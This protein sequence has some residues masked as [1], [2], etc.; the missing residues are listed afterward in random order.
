MLINKVIDGIEKKGS[1]SLATVIDGLH[2]GCR[3]CCVNNENMYELEGDMTYETWKDLIPLIKTAKG[4]KIIDYKHSKILIEHFMKNPILVI[5]GGGHISVPIS[6]IGKMLGFY[7]QVI[8]DREEFADKERFS[9]ADEV[10]CCPFDRLR[11][12]LRSERNTYYVIVTRGH[13][14]DLECA[15][16][17][18]RREFVYAGMIGSK[19]KVAK[20]KNALLE[21]GV[22][23]DKI[24]QLHS[25]IG[26]DIGAQT[27]EEIA[28]SIA[29]EI[30]QDKYKYGY[31]F[32][33]LQLVKE[34]KRE[35]LDGVLVTIIGKTGSSPRGCGSKMFVGRD[36][37]VI[38]TIGGGKV[39]HLAIDQAKTQD[40]IEIKSYS[41]T[42]TD[43]AATG[44]ICGGNVTVLF[45]PIKAEE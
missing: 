31:D 32:L 41:L 13:Q 23:Q 18:L 5:M 4:T 10:I 6:K 19:A 39:E 9:E 43:S 24:D 8:D 38:G 15:T 42:N 1:V 2:K 14:G 26:L 30:I 16:E 35:D 11:E 21:N 25:P 7:V 22:A 27:P 33:P 44:M 36:G 20:T 17:V 37:N 28:V 12:H 45:E 40:K 34:L 29:A 3:L